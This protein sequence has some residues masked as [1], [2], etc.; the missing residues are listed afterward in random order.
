[1]YSHLSRYSSTSSPTAAAGRRTVRAA[2]MLPGPIVFASTP[3]SSGGRPRTSVMA[4][5]TVTGSSPSSCPMR[6]T[7]PSEIPSSG[8]PAADWISTARRMTASSSCE[9]RRRAGSPPPGAG[10]LL[11]GGCRREGPLESV[12]GKVPSA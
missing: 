2:R 12:M 10:G 1:M 6:M 4:R 11:R 3:R 5:R 8:V 9:L 7:S